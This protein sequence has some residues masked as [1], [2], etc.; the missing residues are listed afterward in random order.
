[1]LQLLNFLALVLDVFW[2]LFAV[3]SYGW[4]KCCS[5]YT[6]LSRAVSALSKFLPLQQPGTNDGN[7]RPSITILKPAFALHKLMYFIMRRRHAQLPLAE[8]TA[9]APFLRGT[10]FALLA[11][12]LINGEHSPVLAKFGI[13]LEAPERAWVRL[14]ASLPDIIV[15]PPEDGDR[16]P[17]R[18]QKGGRKLRL[19]EGLLAPPARI[20]KAGRAEKEKRRAER[21]AMAMAA[22]G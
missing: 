9:F 16:A 19:V 13:K 11:N 1:M 12:M 2:L 15:T 3:Q 7:S 18:G 17:E 4:Q 5:L 20:S 8:R 22:R 10:R 21:K 6:A 14:L